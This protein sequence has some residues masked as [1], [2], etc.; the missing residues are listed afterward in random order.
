MHSM[1]FAKIEFHMQN[2]NTLNPEAH[3][4]SRTVTSEFRYD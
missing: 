3:M 4:I 1:P 2:M